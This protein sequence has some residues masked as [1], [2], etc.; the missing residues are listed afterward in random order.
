MGESQGALPAECR[1]R[2]Q[3]QGTWFQTQVLDEKHPLT[4]AI[5]ETTREAL[6]TGPLRRTIW[7]DR[8]QSNYVLCRRFHYVVLISRKK[9]KLAR[10][11]PVNVLFELFESLVVLLLCFDNLV[12][13]ILG[14]DC[15][16]QSSFHLSYSAWVPMRST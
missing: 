3:G 4:K 13:G 6:D 11:C 15:G 8:P 1:R 7:L 2:S 10:R 16:D 14:C 5:L 12:H 9:T